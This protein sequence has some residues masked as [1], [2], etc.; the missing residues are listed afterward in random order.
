M[1]A[2]KGQSTRKQEPTKSIK[3]ANIVQTDGGRPGYLARAKI[4]IS[5]Q[6]HHN[7]KHSALMTGKH[8]LTKN[9][10]SKIKG[11]YDQQRLGVGRYCLK[12]MIHVVIRQR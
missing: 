11:G 7:C 1:R 12:D 8:R 9:R 3:K 10:R 6:Y 2:A 5:V 4:G